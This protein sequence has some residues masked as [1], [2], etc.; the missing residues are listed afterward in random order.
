MDSQGPLFL[1]EPR[2][3]VEF[4]NDTGALLECSANGSP[5]PTL[6]WVSSD[7]SPVEPIPHLR[8][9][10]GNGSLYF[11]PFGAESYRH[12]VHSAV[13][14]CM[15]TNKVGTVLSSEV[16]VR[17]GKCLYSCHPLDAFTRWG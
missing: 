7:G 1:I 16:N 9:T 17:A 5:T 15:A 6:D 2:S 3:I 14:R 12:D 4:A 10:L 11:P 13:Y 8:E